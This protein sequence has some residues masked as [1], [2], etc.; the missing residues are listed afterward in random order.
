MRRRKNPVIDA[1]IMM[2]I[3]RPIEPAMIPA[4]AINRLE[5]GGTGKALRTLTLKK[6]ASGPVIMG[7]DQMK[8]DTTPGRRKRSPFPY[9]YRVLCR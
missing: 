9:A 2:L 1:S 7:G 4:R 3:V 6:T 5:S 8:N